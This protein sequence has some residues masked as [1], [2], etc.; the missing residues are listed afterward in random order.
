MASPR[1]DESLVALERVDGVAVLSLDDQKRR[2]ALSADLQDAL[3]GR[4]SEIRGD[5][6]VRAVV[7][8][9]RGRYFSV[10][11]DVGAMTGDPLSPAEARQRLARLQG[12]VEGLRSLEVP[13]VAA[14]NGPAF[15]G[16]F[17]LALTADFVVAAESATFCASF[18]RFGLVPDVGI[19]H[20]L[21]RLV[22]LALA[23]ELLLTCRSVTAAEA[24]ER[25]FVRSL[26][27]PGEELAAAIALAGRL[28]GASP[29][30]YALTKMML[31]RA[32]EADLT[33][34]L[35]LEA[36]AQPICLDTAYHREALRRFLAREPLAFQWDQE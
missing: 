29:T 34:L 27:P 9:A 10:G 11:G 5:P 30:A 25:G 22:G 31:N 28:G 12:C 6:Q 3:A 15:A 35:E 33:S 4:L 20:A 2:N 16:G 21:T 8:T 18:G 32:A 1:H 7:L 13:L 14:V 24:L 17:S 23:R 36:L 19:V 26:H